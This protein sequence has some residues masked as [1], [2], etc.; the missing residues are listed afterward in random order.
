MMP[1]CTGTPAAAR[2]SAARIDTDRGCA[3]PLPLTELVCISSG[4]AAADVLQGMRRLGFRGALVKERGTRFLGVV[5]EAD[6][7]L[8]GNQDGCLTVREVL[9][10]KNL[11]AAS[12]DTTTRLYSV[13]TR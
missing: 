1:A 4:E 3:P 5:T 12:F 11:A 6:L 9:A 8:Y 13:L 7:R 2:P 10:Q